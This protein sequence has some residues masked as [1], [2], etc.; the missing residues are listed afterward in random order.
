MLAILGLG[1]SNLAAAAEPESLTI[2]QLSGILQV[3]TDLM[4]LQF[5]DAYNACVSKQKGNRSFR[6]TKG[7]KSGSSWSTFSKKFHIS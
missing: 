6:L 4:K 1:Y 5:P 7:S 3:Y 2:A